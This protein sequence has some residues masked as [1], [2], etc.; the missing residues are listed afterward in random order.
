VSGKIKPGA[1]TGAEGKKFA[2]LATVHDYRGL[3]EDEHEKALAVADAPIEEKVR[4]IF[5]L[6]STLRFQTH[7]TAKELSWAWNLKIG[8]VR[9]YCSRAKDIFNVMSRHEQ[10]PDAYRQEIQL[11]YEHL[12][13][14]ALQAKKP[15]LKTNKETGEQEIVYAEAPDVKAA[16]TATKAIAELQGAHR[17]AVVE[18][19]KNKYEEQDMG[20]EEMLALAQKKIE[21]EDE[22]EDGRED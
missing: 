15:M 2:K 7:R 12:T 18:A 6:M 3:S 5:E 17:N 11:K 13:N 9:G 10:S 21:E 14:L 16:I 22:E 4:F 20:L 8:T 19:M 1:G